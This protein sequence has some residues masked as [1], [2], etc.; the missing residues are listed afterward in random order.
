MVIMSSPVSSAESASSNSGSTLKPYLRRKKSSLGE[1]KIAILG[2]AGV[3]K[4]ALC[5]R[6]LTK[7]FIGEYDQANENKYKCVIM[8]EGESVTFEL[9]DTRS[10]DE[11]MGAR[12]DV[13]RWSDGFVLV[14]SVT[15]RQT[16]EVLSEVRRKLEDM[17][18]VSHVPVILVGNKADLAHIRQV[19]QDEGA[20]LAA[21]LCCS[22]MEVSASE[23]VTKVTDAFHILCREIIEYKRRSRTFLDRVF[24]LKKS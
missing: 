6:F 24:G 11:D 7:R 10:N 17:K 14:Y 21:D 4:S 1:T 19:S 9:L 22:F 18:K 5:V 3:G 23:D 16:F 2:M 8:L 15:S 13:V 20:R 12:E